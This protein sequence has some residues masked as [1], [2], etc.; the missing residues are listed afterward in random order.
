MSRYD[1]KPINKEQTTP[2]DQIVLRFGSLRK[3]AR[4]ENVHK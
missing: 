2:R 4:L 3:V 1:G